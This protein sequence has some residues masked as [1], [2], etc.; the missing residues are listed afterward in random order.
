M[1][2]LTDSNPNIINI[3]TED[4]T[5]DLETWSDPSISI[6][7]ADVLY[8]ITVN[9]NNPAILYAVITD[10]APQLEGGNSKLIKQGY[11]FTDK[12]RLKVSDHVPKEVIFE[13]EFLFA[14]YLYCIYRHPEHKTKL[15]LDVYPNSGDGIEGEK[16]IYSGYLIP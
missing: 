4:G 1:S 10:L 13:R 9:P 8:N 16:T 5:L 14:G 15:Y 2:K 12:E 7:Y 3:N 6:G 11:L